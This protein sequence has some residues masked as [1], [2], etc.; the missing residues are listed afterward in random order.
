MTDTLNFLL[1][2]AKG[3]FNIFIDEGGILGFGIVVA[4][5]V[6]RVVNFMKRFFK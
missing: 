5:V 6:P 1:S 3:Y 4:F 2:T